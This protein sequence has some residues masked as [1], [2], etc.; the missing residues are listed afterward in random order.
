MADETIDEVTTDF[1]QYQADVSAKMT[2][3][4]NEVAASGGVPPAVQAKIDDLGSAIRAADAALT[5]T[6][7]T[8]GTGGSG[9]TPSLST[10][11][12]TDPSAISPAAG[13]VPAGQQAVLPADTAGDGVQHE[14][15]SVAPAPEAVEPGTGAA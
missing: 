2:E 1:G 14:D 7:V 12:A 3:L 9:T 6:G 10:S 5:A 4:E 15:G 11:P 8:A 13:I